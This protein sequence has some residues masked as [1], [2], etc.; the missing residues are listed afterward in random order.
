MH[1]AHETLLQSADCLPV[2]MT[3]ARIRCLDAGLGSPIGETVV[4][5]GHID[6][7]STES[8]QNLFLKRAEGTAATL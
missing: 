7:L 8:I 5:P 4:K 6:P 2:S 1:R 3:T